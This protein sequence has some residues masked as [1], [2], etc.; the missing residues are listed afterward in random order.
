MT[1]VSDYDQAICA[2]EWNDGQVVGLCRAHRDRFEL[3]TKA[4]HPQGPFA[5]PRLMI[6]ETRDAIGMTAAEASKRAGMHPVTWSDVERG[7]TG[8]PTL[9]TMVRMAAA[10]GVSV[11]D[12]IREEE[13]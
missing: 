6:R 8:N 7:K 3:E 1:H 2:C 12:L 9:A 13:P 5:L 11:R 10:L 4:D